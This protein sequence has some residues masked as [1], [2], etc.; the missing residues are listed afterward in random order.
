MEIKLRKS[1]TSIILSINIIIFAIVNK[2]LIIKNCRKLVFINSLLKLLSTVLS[3]V[4][5]NC[6]RQKLFIFFSSH[7]ALKI[8]YQLFNTA[9]SYYYQH[10]KQITYMNIKKF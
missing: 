2:I 1:S 8:F 6:D 3:T 7:R 10:E 4:Q 5:K 9:F